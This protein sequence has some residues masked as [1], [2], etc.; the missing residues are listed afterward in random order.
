[1]GYFPQMII[2][3]ISTIILLLILA[4][5]EFDIIGVQAEAQ[6]RLILPPPPPTPSSSIANRP[7][8]RRTFTGSRDK[9]SRPSSPTRSFRQSR[10]PPVP[11]PSSS[12]TQVTEWERHRIQK[13][14]TG[15]F[16]FPPVSVS[17]HRPHTSSQAT[18]KPLFH[19]R[20]TTLT[21]MRLMESG[22]VPR[23]H[24]FDDDYHV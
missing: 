23:S 7:Q 3:T 10:P 22:Q 21:K 19:R 8:P 11:G 24:W 15:Q 9:D 4:V 14:L 17:T 20:V 2:S 1:M 5:R 16:V 13:H 12:P 18:V 6:H